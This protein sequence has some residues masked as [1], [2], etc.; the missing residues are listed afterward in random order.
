MGLLTRKLKGSF[1]QGM[2]SVLC[3]DGCYCLRQKPV[4]RDRPEP[5]LERNQ[6]RWKTEVVIELA[7]PPPHQLLP[8][9]P[10]VLCSTEQPSRSEPPPPAWENLR[11]CRLS[12]E[13]TQF[14]QF[15]LGGRPGFDDGA[16]CWPFL[17]LQPL[18]C[19][20]SESGG[21]PGLVLGITCITWH[22][23]E[24]QILRFC[25]LNQKLD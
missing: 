16:I 25:S 1:F 17:T 8:M 7:I 5:S 2:E 14:H 12:P 6:Q 21:S 19:S 13:L 18:L 4:W 11:F 15:P 9:L 24:M 10:S 3:F 20:F 23:L 22:L